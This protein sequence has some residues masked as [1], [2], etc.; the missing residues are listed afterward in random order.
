MNT[1]SLQLFVDVARAGSFAKA[2]D[3]HGLDPSIVSRRISKLERELGFRLFQRTTRM[4]A[5]TEAGTEFFGRIETHLIAIHEARQAGQDL[6][7]QPIGV[8]RVTASTSFG[9]EILS[10]LL[11]EFLATAPALRVELVLTDRR[12]NLLEEG[13]DLAVRLGGLPDSELVATKLMP[14]EFRLYG[15]EK[16]RRPGRVPRE[17]ECVTYT[18]AAETVQLRSPKGSTHTIRLSSRLAASNA[19]VMKR[20][21]SMGLAPGLLPNWLVTTELATGEL[22][23]LFPDYAYTTDA[24]LAAW[25][26]YPTRLYVPAKVRSFIE[27]YRARV[28]TD[29]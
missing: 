25:F 26:V 4:M 8:L 18:G 15:H 22:I 13:I 12:I 19:L 20:C 7:E 6:T 21:V 3:V 28:N 5:L 27:F 1:E 16:F 10:P 17:L 24:D 23:E 29:S 2:A 11:P 9:Y 14:I